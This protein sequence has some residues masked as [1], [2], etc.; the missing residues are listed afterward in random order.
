MRLLLVI[1]HFGA[2]GAQVQLVKLGLQL[3]RAGHEVEYFVYY[4]DSKLRP[5]LDAA[6]VQ[7]WQSLKKHRYGL[8]CAAALRR[9]LLVGRYDLALAYLVTPSFYLEIARLGVPDLRVVVSERSQYPQGRLPWRRFLLEQFHRSAD[10]IV[11]NS[12]AQCE[13]M[14]QEFPWMRSRITVIQNGVDDRFFAVVPNLARR[15]AHLRLLA[16]GTINPTKNPMA[17]I[18]ALAIARDKHQCNV[19]L[20]WAGRVDRGCEQYMKSVTAR[21]KELGLER[22][23]AWLGHQEDVARQMELHDALIH[24]SIREGMSNAICE[25]MAA[26]MPILAGSVGDHER[27]VGASGA[28]FLFDV[29]SSS[30]IADKIAA[31]CQSSDEA[32]ARY[33]GNARTFARVNLTMQTC[34]RKYETLFSSL[35]CRD[36]FTSRAPLN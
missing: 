8:G 2:G 35:V 33:A 18:E 36:K 28:G 19:T 17:A 6:G 31:L 14:V 15:G 23:V 20:S 22:S 24:P 21:V 9:R 1:D 27:L 16:I 25:A 11:V 29:T 13:R 4:P 10:H 32:W 34:T 5:L 3:L 12:F 26:G 7:V 30:D